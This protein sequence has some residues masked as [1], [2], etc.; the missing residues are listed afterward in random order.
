MFCTGYGSE[1]VSPVREQTCQAVDTMAA[2]VQHLV[3]VNIFIFSF[4]LV[5]SAPLGLGLVCVT[6]LELVALP[7]FFYNLWTEQDAD[8]DFCTPSGFLTIQASHV[9]GVREEIEQT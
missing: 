6:L 8:M 7:R 1:F 5:S 9:A 4:V 3:G 2:K